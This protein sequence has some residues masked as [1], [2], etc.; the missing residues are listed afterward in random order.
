[1]TRTLQFVVL[2]I[3]IFITALSFVMFQGGFDVKGSVEETNEYMATSTAASTIYGATITGDTLIR[4]GTGSLA[5]ITITGA[6]SGIFNIYNATTTNVDLRTG[7]KATSTILIVSFPSSVA[8]GT[9]TFDAQYT[10]GLYLDLVS[11]NMPT[12]TILYR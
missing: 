5:Q 8:T 6:A 10:D 11:G 9:Y 1:M 7:N 4:T 3:A 2:S 12:S